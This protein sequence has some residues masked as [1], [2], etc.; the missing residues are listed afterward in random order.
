VGPV[1]LSRPGQAFGDPAAK[2]VRVNLEV[3]VG[4]QQIVIAPN[5]GRDRIEVLLGKAPLFAAG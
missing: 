2:L 5:P 1:F 4:H 3:P